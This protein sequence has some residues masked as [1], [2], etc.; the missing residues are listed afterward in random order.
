MFWFIVT[1]PSVSSKVGKLEV[2]SLC[3]IRKLFHVT[4]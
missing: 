2:K 1:D 4:C 3:V